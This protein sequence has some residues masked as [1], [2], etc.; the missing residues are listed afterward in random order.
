MIFQIVDQYSN[1]S[2]STKIVVGWVETD[3]EGKID[4]GLMFYIGTNLIRGVTKNYNLG[5]AGE[6]V[7]GNWE[8]T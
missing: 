2:D 1:L 3:E 6:H 5:G 8:P 7:L 4:F